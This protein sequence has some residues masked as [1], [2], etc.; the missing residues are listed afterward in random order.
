MQQSSVL[1]TGAFSGIGL[2]LAQHYARE[3]VTLFLGDRDETLLESAT[4][5]CQ[6]YGA[7]VRAHIVDVT[8]TPAMRDW[9]RSCDEHRALN[10]VIA[11]AGVARGAAD[12]E[13]LH[14]AADYSFSV[15]VHGTFNTVH[16]AL[17]IMAKRRPYPVADAQIAMMSSVMGYAG[18]ARAPAYSASKA[19]VK[20]YG[21]AMRGALRGMGIKISVICPGYVNTGLMT[22]HMA[23]LPF[24]MPVENAAETIVKGLAADKPTVTF[25][26]QMRIL[27][28][29]A[30]N[31]PGFLADR[32]NQ[33]WGVPRYEDLD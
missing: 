14:D 25:P 20:S 4:R 24:V 18:M 3:G 28:R 15:N 19:A 32:L 10:L 7:E 23:N 5:A 6:A 12:V 16:P 17:E 22:G 13:G 9:V 29:I 27:A 8:D 26:W 30:A 2:A 21:Q 11:N 33:P 1:I 31:Q